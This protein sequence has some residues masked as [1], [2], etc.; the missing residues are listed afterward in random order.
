MAPGGGPAL[1]GGPPPGVCGAPAPARPAP[2]GAPPAPR[3]TISDTRPASAQLGE[4]M[5]YDVRV[6]NTGSAA[7]GPL[8]WQFRLSRAG[9]A[10][11]A[12]DVLLR[13]RVGDEWRRINLRPDGTGALA[14]TVTDGFTLAVD[15]GREWTV[16]LE[17]RREAGDY[18]IT[19]RVTGAGVDVANTDTIALARARGGALVG[20][21]MDAG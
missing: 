20:T 19:D 21:A 17:I 16:S 18:T 10:A 12:R 15:A 3:V 13:L 7:T 8:T 1:L 6:A 2:R 5:I 11:D 4:A 9:G 14:G